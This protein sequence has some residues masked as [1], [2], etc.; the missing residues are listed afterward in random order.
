MSVFS[1]VKTLSLEKVF[2]KRFNKT[3]DSCY[4]KQTKVDK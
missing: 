3:L 4:E 2:T 1:L